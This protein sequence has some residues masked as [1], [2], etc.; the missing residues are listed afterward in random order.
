M[1][2]FFMG[3]TIN[4]PEVELLPSK[5]ILKLEGRSIPEDPGDF[6]NTIMSKLEEYY[7]YPNEITQIDFKLE[8]VNS[9]SSKALL[10]L[11]RFVKENYDSGKNCIVNWYF[12][13]D[14]ESIHELGLHFQ[15]SFNIPFKLINFY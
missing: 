5:G 14:D 3:K 2:D 10:E 15:S 8:Y 6:Y 12:E 13:E 4:T 11:L 9:G 1:N 7:Q